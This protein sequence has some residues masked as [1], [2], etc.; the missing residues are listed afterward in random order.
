MAFADAVAIVPIS[1]TEKAAVD[2]STFVTPDGT[3]GNKFFANANTILHV[4]NTNAA[5]RTV[6]IDV[7]RTVEGQA[8]ADDT[9]VVPATTGDVMYTGFSDIFKQNAAGQVHITF[10]AVLNVTVQVLQL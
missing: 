10:S 4:K 9:F 1:L 3:N 2:T 7:T 6:T 5:T 8:V